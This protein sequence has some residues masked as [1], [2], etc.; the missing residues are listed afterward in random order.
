MTF[1]MP[2]LSIFLSLLILLLSLHEQYSAP[3]DVGSKIDYP[4]SH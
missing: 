2:F 3:I 4:L 1:V